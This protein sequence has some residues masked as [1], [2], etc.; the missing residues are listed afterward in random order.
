[1][2]QLTPFTESKDNMATTY[3]KIATNSPTGTTNTVAF[4]SI[5]STYTDLRLVIFGKGDY[6]NFDGKINS[7]T[8]ANY[9]YTMFSANGTSVS[10]AHA[11]DL[12]YLPAAVSLSTYGVPTLL[13]FDFFSYAGAT[14]KTILATQSFDRNG[15]GATYSWVNLWRSTSAINRIDITLGAGTNYVGSVLSLYGITAA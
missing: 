8:G 11:S 7:D 10:S 13:T 3:E 14:K 4:T 1:M 2:A 9:S 5:P 12:T 6:G 15:A